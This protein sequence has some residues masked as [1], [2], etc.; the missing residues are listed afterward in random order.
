MI[1]SS[2]LIFYL[3]NPVKHLL[4]SQY[5]VIRYIVI[6]N[7]VIKS[8]FQIAISAK[9]Y[10][11]MM[12]PTHLLH[13]FNYSFFLMLLMKLLNIRNVFNRIT[14]RDLFKVS[15]KNQR[16]N[17]SSNCKNNTRS[18]Y[19]LGWK[20]L[21]KSSASWKRLC[22]RNQRKYKKL[23]KKGKNHQSQKKFENHCF[24]IRKSVQN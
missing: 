2:R 5:N 4:Y 8:M 9:K 1:L 18:L 6:K 19:H 10:N 24:G 23:L 20:N 22:K 3:K 15:Q 16:C 7:W 12:L 17:N 14:I 21:M 13:K 11:L